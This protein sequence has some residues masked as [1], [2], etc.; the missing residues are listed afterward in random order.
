MLLK[1]KPFTYN[2]CF[3]HFFADF[4]FPR[5]SSVG[6]WNGELCPMISTMLGEP[7]PRRSHT[8]THHNYKTFRFAFNKLSAVLCC[9]CNATTK[10]EKKN[11]SILNVHRMVQVHLLKI[12]GYGMPTIDFVCI[13]WQVNWLNNKSGGILLS[14]HSKRMAKNRHEHCCRLL[15]STIAM[16]IIIV[17]LMEYAVAPFRSLCFVVIAF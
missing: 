8:K 1:R 11:S 6:C 15:V 7:R 12:Y 5:L 3:F 2:D 4:V 9:S 16:R 13:M 14:Y 10:I 17:S